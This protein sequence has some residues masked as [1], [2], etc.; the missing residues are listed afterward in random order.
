LVVIEGTAGIGKT[1]LLGEVRAIA[2]SVGMQVLAARGGELEGEFAF[3]IVRQLFEQLLAAAPP[4]LREELLSGPAE[5]VEPLFGAAQ[6]AG[7]QDAPAEGSFAILHGLYWLAANVGFHQPTLLAI[8]DVHW[9]DTPSLEWLLFLTRRLEG[10]P[11]LVA[12]ATRPPEA[13][14]REPALVA[15]LVADPDVASIRPEPLGSGSIAVLARELHGLE[16][17]EA[18][19]V[20]LH[21]ATGGTR[22]SSTPCSTRSRERGSARSPRTPRAWSRPGLR[23][24]LGSWGFASLAC[25]RRRSPS[26]GPPR[27]WATGSSSVTRQLWPAWK[28]VRLVRPSPIHVRALEFVVY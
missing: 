13:E 26:S 17:D 5:L 6:P 1:R 23:A 14:S 12:A 2:G 8:D 4:N 19:S 28:R 11:L 15:E 20:A 18:F 16:P 10:L 22:S 7:P 3:G 24:S 21:T 9:A 25:S 27:S